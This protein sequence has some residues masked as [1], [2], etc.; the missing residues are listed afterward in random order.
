MARMQEYASGGE[1]L[2]LGSYSYYMLSSKHLREEMDVFATHGIK[3]RFR[4]LARA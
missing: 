4:L 2:K 3:S 1:I